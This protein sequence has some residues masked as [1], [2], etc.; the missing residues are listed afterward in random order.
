MVYPKCILWMDHLSIGLLT[1]QI[2]EINLTLTPNSTNE[3]WNYR[4]ADPKQTSE[5]YNL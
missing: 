5:S 2:L 4:Y 3:R 1:S